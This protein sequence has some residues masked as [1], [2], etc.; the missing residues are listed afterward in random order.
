M[1]TQV[2]LAL[3]LHFAD[4]STFSDPGFGKTLQKALNVSF[5]IY[6]LALLLF[7]TAVAIILCEFHVVLNNF[8]AFLY[9][10]LCII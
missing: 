8:L 1:S 7:A 5:T 4:G 6:V 9:A 10:L 3:L 2:R